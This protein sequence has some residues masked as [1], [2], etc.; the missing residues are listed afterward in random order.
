[1]LKF[2]SGDSDS[3]NDAS[4]TNHIDSGVDDSSAEDYD[5][6]E[7]EEGQIKLP[8]G[9]IMEDI[10]ELEAEKSYLIVYVRQKTDEELA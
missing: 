1:M 5:D 9:I 8:D 6:D 10:N 3:E 4:Q 7:P 2:K